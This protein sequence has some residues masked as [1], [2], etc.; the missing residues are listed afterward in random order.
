MGVNQNELRFMEAFLA[1]CLLRTSAPIEPAEQQELDDNHLLVARR[2]REPGLQLK[3]DGRDVPLQL[4]A[5]ELLDAMQGICEL[6]D[7]GDASRPYQA[8]LRAQG[9]K[10]EDVAQTPSAR[11][12]AE[13]RTT[14]ESF[15]ELALRMSG[16]HKAYFL[17]LYP[18]ND[19]RLREFASE[20][21]QS[22]AQ[23]RAMEAA[24]R[25]SFEVYLEKYFAAATR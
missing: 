12:L 11:M 21:Q 6:L 23:Q 8:A 2:G 22:L 5:R 14:G 9:E 4:W 7:Q 18:P 10:L 25:D 1:L 16:L 17:E 3:R 24:D 20:A 19:A 13:L 15:Y